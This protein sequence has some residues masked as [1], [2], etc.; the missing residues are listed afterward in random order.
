MSPPIEYRCAHGF[1]RSL[2]KCE[3]CDAGDLSSLSEREPGESPNFK[4]L[5]N[6][7]VA[8]CLV[9]SRAPN[10]GGRAR[11]RCICDCGEIFTEDGQYLR[12]KEKEGRVACCVN[13]RWKHVKP[14]KPRATKPKP[15]PVQRLGVPNPH[16]KAKP[17]VPEHAEPA[18]KRAVG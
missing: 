3:V 8:G 9:Q 11:W 10:V 6:K 12:V 14:R 7:R 16:L 18:P 13:C 1:L 4:D 5:T 15:P 2:I 17:I